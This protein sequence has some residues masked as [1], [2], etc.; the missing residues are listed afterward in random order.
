LQGRRAARH[1]QSVNTI[2]T[3][4][5]ILREYTEDDA[6]AFFRL[7]S[8]P[9][10]MRYVPDQPM[11]SVEQ[12]R[13]VL[14][15]HPLTDYRERGYGRFACV[16]KDTG[17]HIGFSG[18]KYIPEIG[19]VDLGFRFLPAYWGKGLA[20]EAAEASLR[21]GFEKLNLEQII[22]LAEPENHASIRVLEKVGMQFTG[23][24]RLWDREFKRHVVRR[25][26]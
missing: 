2:F 1:L 19:G 16:L 11:Q 20:T 13:Q 23:L 6:P 7:N 12:A 10:V 21:Y 18:L 9:Q 4:R 24:V 25:N 14:V 5:L 22:G 17:E 26:A 3:E 8:D 15:S